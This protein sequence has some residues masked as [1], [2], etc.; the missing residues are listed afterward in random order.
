MAASLTIEMGIEVE[1]AGDELTHEESHFNGSTLGNSVFDKEL[2]AKGEGGWIESHMRISY[3]TFSGKSSLLQ[4][5]RM[6]GHQEDD[7]ESAHGQV[8]L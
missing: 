1:A 3:I 7:S 8:L 2:L 6:M 4:V 5:F